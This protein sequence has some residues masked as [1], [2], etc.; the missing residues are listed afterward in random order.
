MGKGEDSEFNMDGQS[1]QIQ[2]LGWRAD[3]GARGLEAGQKTLGDKDY[4]KLLR[5]NMKQIIKL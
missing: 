3:E 4:N 2:K 1:T 5:Q